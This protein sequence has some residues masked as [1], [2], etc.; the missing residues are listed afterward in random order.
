MVRQRKSRVVPHS[1]LKHL[2]SGAALALELGILPEVEVFR[3]RSGTPWDLVEV[4]FLEV[5]IGGSRELT[6]PAH[7]N[8]VVV[9]RP[10]FQSKV[11]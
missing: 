10:M 6:A 7:Q 2:A 1:L 9:K 8:P 4:T 11:N 3:F 5:S